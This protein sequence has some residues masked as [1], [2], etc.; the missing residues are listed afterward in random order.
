MAFTA[1]VHVSDNIG[2]TT[3]CLTL[4]P[5]TL[6][7]YFGKTDIISEFAGNIDALYFRGG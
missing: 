1:Q 2:N 7:T 5:E 6:N 4:F 3:E